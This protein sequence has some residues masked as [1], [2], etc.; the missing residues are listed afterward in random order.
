MFKNLRYLRLHS[1]DKFN[2]YLF[3][4]N[5]VCARRLIGNWYWVSHF[6]TTQRDNDWVT[7]FST[8]EQ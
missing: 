2:F 7:R 4:N 3:G 1:K 8:K 5:L 6:S